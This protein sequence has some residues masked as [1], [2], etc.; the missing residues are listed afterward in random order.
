MNITLTEAQIASIVSDNSV[1]YSK[2][3]IITSPEQAYEAVKHYGKLKQEHF[4]I[5][6]LDGANRLIQIHEISKGTI[7]A[8][9]VHPRE[10]FKRAIDDLASSFIACHNHP[11]GNL[12]AS[13]A[14]ID[15]TERLQEVGKLVGINIIDH[16][17]IT[18]DSYN[19]I[20]KIIF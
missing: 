16:L 2:N 9:L 15:V 4:L 19:S 5:L 8:S 6:T 14:D 1:D 20:I 3:P 12:K 17:I 13:N 11:S 7:T 10:V 18:K